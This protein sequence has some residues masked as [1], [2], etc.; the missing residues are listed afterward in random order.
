MT[1]WREGEK[2]SLFILLVYKPVYP[3][4]L[5]DHCWSYREF[6]GRSLQIERFLFRDFF[7]DM[8]HPI[9][10]I[11]FLVWEIFMTHDECVGRWTIPSHHPKIMPYRHHTLYPIPLPFVWQLVPDDGVGVHHPG[12]YRGFGTMAGSEAHGSW[13]CVSSIFVIYAILRSREWPK[14]DYQNSLV[15]MNET[16]KKAF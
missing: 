4:I 1:A 7:Y 12:N 13:H 6:K 5:W 2:G 15:F 9:G 16:R 14:P 11:E 10:G 8:H 3:L